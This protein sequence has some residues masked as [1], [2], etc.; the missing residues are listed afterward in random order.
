MVA[1]PSANFILARHPLP[2]LCVRPHVFLILSILTLTSILYSFPPNRASTKRRKPFLDDPMTGREKIEK[3]DER[4]RG[5]EGEGREGDGERQRDRDR[6]K[7]RQRDTDTE[8]HRHRET[9]TQ[10]ETDT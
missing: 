10:R 2:I 8:R 5:R 4:G 9:Q 7:Q 3:D 6:E 1:L